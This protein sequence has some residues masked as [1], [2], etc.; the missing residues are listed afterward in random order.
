[1]LHCW[2]VCRYFDPETVGLDFEGM[3][4]D[5]EAAPEG[6]IIVLHGQALVQKPRLWSFVETASMTLRPIAL[7]C[8]RLLKQL[9]MPLHHSHVLTWLQLPF[10]QIP[11]SFAVVC[12]DSSK[13]P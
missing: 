8:H 12:S 3:A 5:L 4:S 6:S 1:M 2:F 7:V 13:C 10:N 11:L 9:P